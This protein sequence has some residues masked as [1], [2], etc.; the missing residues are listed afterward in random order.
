[1]FSTPFMSSSHTTAVL[2]DGC[3]QILDIANDYCRGLSS[4]QAVRDCILKKYS[5]S[6]QSMCIKN[7]KRATKQQYDQM[8]EFSAL[9]EDKLNQAIA[10]I[11]SDELI[12]TSADEFSCSISTTTRKLI[13]IP[14]VIPLILMATVF[15]F[16]YNI[17]PMIYYGA[18]YCGSFT[19]HILKLTAAL[20]VEKYLDP[21]LTIG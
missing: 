5:Q 12:P 20:I 10:F 6:H 1:M 19:Y 9:D 17:I 8:V 18:Y 21:K 2:P 3:Q 15:A 13:E 11:V 14:V 16:S 4:L 7:M